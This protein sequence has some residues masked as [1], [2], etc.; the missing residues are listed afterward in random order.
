MKT[1]II[2]LAVILG[3]GVFATNKV[4]A[5]ESKIKSLTESSFNAGIKNGVV[6]VDFYADWCKPCKLQKPVLE[7]I[8]GEYSSKITIAS[9]NTDNAPTL[10]EKFNITGI[11]CMIIFKDGKEVKR[12]IGFHAKEDMLTEL[13]AYIK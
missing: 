10:S 3:L 9:V 4:K 7:E 13:A 2:I 5:Q 11:P 8:A 12:I 6:M 1:K